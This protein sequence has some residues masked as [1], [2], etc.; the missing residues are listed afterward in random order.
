M[1]GSSSRSVL[2]CLPAVLAPL[3]AHLRCACSVPLWQVIPVCAWFLTPQHHDV[4]PA[5]EFACSAF[6]C[7][8]AAKRF[9]ESGRS[10]PC[11]A[12][13]ERIDRVLGEPQLHLVCR[14][15]VRYFQLV[16]LM[17]TNVLTSVFVFCVAQRNWRRSRR[18]I[19]M[20]TTTSAF[21]RWYVACFFLASTLNPIAL[22]SAPLADRA[23]WMACSRR[24]RR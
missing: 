2:S 9:R 5:H 8:R 18:V 10:L 22:P 16:A 13:R 21:R 4:L 17:V 23:L 3:F 15:R 24:S 19:C 6:A 11:A 20:C 1:T 12:S 7:S 14:Q